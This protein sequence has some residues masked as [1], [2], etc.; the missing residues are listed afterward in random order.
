MSA[1]LCF[2]FLL[3][4]CI[5]RHY[6]RVAFDEYGAPFHHPL[7]EKVCRHTWTLVVLPEGLVSFLR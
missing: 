6:V 2:L 7:R 4:E 5:K 1:H 3:A